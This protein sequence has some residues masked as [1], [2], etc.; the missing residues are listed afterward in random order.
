[1]TIIPEGGASKPRGSEQDVAGQEG[2]LDRQRLGGKSIWDWLDLLSKL[3]I[4][5]VVVL[6]TVGFGAWQNHLADQQHQS[7]QN[8]A[9]DQQRAAILQTYI[10]NMQDLLVNHKLSGSNPTAEI[11]LAAKEQT[12]T[13]LRRLDDAGSN[14][15]VLQFLR[16]AHLIGTQDAVIDFRNTDLSNDNLSRADL[17]GIDLTGATLIGAQLNGADLSG[18]TLGAADLSDANLSDANLSGAYLFG[19][20][21]SGTNL[22]RATLSDATLTSAFLGG[23]NIDRA[24]LTGAHLNDANLAA[25]HLDGAHLSGADL[26]DAELAHAELNGADISDA[27]LILAVGLSQ[28]QLDTVSSCTSAIIRSSTLRCHRDGKINLTYWYTESPAETPVIRKLINQFEQQNPTI[29]INAVKKYYYAAKAAFENDA[30]EGGAPDVLRS[31]I[32]WVARFASQGY[33]LNIDSYIGQGDDLSDYL[34]APLAYNHYDGHFY[35]L[36]Q[37]TDFLALLYNKAE[38]EK[39]GVSSA[40]ATMADFE[41]DA[42]KVVQSR[43][44]RYAFETDGTGY[45]IL[46]FLYSFGGGMLDRNNKIAVNSTGSVNGLNFLLKLQSIDRVMPQNVNYSNGSATSP[47]ADLAIG[48]T[49]MIFGGPY[50]LLQILAGPEFKS[51][52]GNLGIASIP[53]CP[54]G[55]P[56]CHA[57]QAGSPNGGQSYVISADT[58][59]PR[60]AY[61]FISFMSSKP[62]QIAIAEANHT[63]P[64]RKSAQNAVS[65]ENFI[66]EFLN[67]AS[68]AVTQ[69]VLPQIESLFDSFDP[70]IAAA[71]DGSESPAA[72]LNAVADAWK[73][74]LAS[75]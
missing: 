25:A 7:D 39:A 36:P 22:S 10:G 54:A 46:P 3:A 56:T 9:L 75:P 31:D 64:T 55:I 45:N 47:V 32:G 19:A 33:L 40:P 38:L 50:D 69:S 58:K 42:E 11:S 61:K 4:P 15:I 17:S 13:A 51:N 23:A 53:T 27:D 62:S 12:L 73:Q 2:P 41:R 16:D 52:P 68:T 18:V 71:L 57:G 30:E 63:L 1:V 35:G 60:E 29:H 34:S 43:A 49:A 37:V 14:K 6:A 70:N 59:H 20:R 44:A 74:L 26:D 8:Q 5:L 21:L 24:N 66:S 65:G 67:L 48:K 28:H 72:A